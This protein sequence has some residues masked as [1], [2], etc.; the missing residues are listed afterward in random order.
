MLREMRNDILWCYKS[1]CKKLKET[2][3]SLALMCACMLCLVVILMVQ[4]AP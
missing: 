3:I 2:L 1:D 4:A